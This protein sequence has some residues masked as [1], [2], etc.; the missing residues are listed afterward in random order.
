MLQG[1]S[2]YAKY[3]LEIDQSN[4][5]AAPFYILIHS[6]EKMQLYDGVVVAEMDTSDKTLYNFHTYVQDRIVPF[7]KAGLSE[8]EQMAWLCERNTDYVLVNDDLDLFTIVENLKYQD[9]F[10]PLFEIKAM[11]KNDRHYRVAAYRFIKKIGCGAEI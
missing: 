8:T 1:A 11:G 2:V 7:E 3:N 6:A 9:M 10:T 5:H 4:Y